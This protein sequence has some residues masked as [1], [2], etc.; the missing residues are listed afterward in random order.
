MFEEKWNAYAQSWSQ[1]D[2]TCEAALLDLVTDD[3]AYADPS[4]EVAGRAAFAAHMAQFR[5]D[6]PGASFEII[7]VKGHHDQTL[8]RW[9]L[10]GQ[11]G[12][13]MMLG[14]SYATLEQD[15]KFS[16]FTGFF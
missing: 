8:A 15:G 1:P 14:T 7:D 12:S 9:R 13:E 3:V 5:K 11:D 2:A 16:S 4:S 10:N 6:V